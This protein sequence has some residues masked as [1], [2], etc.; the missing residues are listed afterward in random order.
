MEEIKEEKRKITRQE[1]IHIIF[2]ILM[3]IAIGVLINTTIVILK[4]REMLQNPVGYNLDKF[5]INYCTC[6]DNSFKIIPIKGLSY[7]DSFE[8]FIPKQ[9]YTT[10]KLLNLSSFNITN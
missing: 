6:Y 4:Y 7:N 10:Q 3:I 5:G 8:N 2:I 1:V 9:E